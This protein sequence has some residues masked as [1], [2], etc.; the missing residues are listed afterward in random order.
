VQAEQKL[1]AGKFFR[2]VCLFQTNSPTLGPHNYSWILNDSG[3]TVV[4]VGSISD[5]DDYD[6]YY[7]SD[8]DT[9][10]NSCG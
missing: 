2:Q 10:G 8:A 6:L 1:T 7:C 3:N 9:T 4:S 5:S